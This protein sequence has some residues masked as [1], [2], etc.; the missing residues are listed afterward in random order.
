MEGIK[1]T[2]TWTR[3]GDRVKNRDMDRVRDLD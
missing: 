1:G 2:W 3:Q